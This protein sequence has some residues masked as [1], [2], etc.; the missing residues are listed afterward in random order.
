MQSPS[1]SNGSIVSV[2][3]PNESAGCDLQLCSLVSQK[4]SCWVLMIVTPPYTCIHWTHPI[5]TAEKEN[6]NLQFMYL[7]VIFLNWPKNNIFVHPV[8]GC[9]VEITWIVF[10]LNS[11][12][13]NSISTWFNEAGLLF[14]KTLELTTLFNLLSYFT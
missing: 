1:F 4:R 11:F 7:Q 2:K 14:S 5:P 6:L 12:S 13:W 9:Q 10:H 8:F 3:S